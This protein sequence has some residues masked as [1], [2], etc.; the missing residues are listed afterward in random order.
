MEPIMILKIGWTY[1]NT[2]GMLIGNCDLS[3]TAT[4][5]TKEELVEMM[6]DA[7]VLLIEDLIEDGDLY[8]YIRE[9]GSLYPIPSVE[10][11][12]VECVGSTITDNAV[13]LEIQ[14]G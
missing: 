12:K 10:F 1:Q 4:G 2:C 7:T 8:S 13:S 9:W 6:K 3:I 11:T 5:S 14:L